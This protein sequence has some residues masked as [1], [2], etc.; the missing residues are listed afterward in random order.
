MERLFKKTAGDSSATV[1]I[2]AVVVMTVLATVAV[3]L[4]QLSGS[5]TR[6]AAGER[7]A[8][9]SFA[10]GGGG[11]QWA[12][13]RL[14]KGNDPSIAQKALGGGSFSITTDPQGSLLTS[15]GVVGTAQRAQTVRANFSKDCVKLDTKDAYSEIHLIA[16]NE[17]VQQVL[18]NV[19]LIKTCNE[20]AVLDKIVLSWNW[21]W[22]AKDVDCPCAQSGNEEVCGQKDDSCLATPASENAL[23][24]CTNDSGGAKMTQTELG[25]KVV[26][27]AGILPEGSQKVTSGGDV[28]VL[29][30]V[31][32]NNTTYEL[33]FYFDMPVIPGAWYTAT[34]VFVDLSEL[35]S[36]FKAGKQN[37]V[38]SGQ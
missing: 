13:E 18:K 6:Q 17:F 36:K 31:L 35:N 21:G 5:D 4:L 11:L 12:L 26:F 27:K 3:A 14:D 23:G 2:E 19:L 1:M 7:Q 30:A 10:V 38:I 15:R 33:N 9:Q 8:W 29:G 22:C 16:E 24:V 32:E 28:V 20:R 37:V 25:G 34:P